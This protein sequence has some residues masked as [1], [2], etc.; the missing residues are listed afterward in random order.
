[1]ITNSSASL[2]T[3]VESVA[4]S[5]RALSGSAVGTFVEFYDFAIYA[6]T[7]PII[8]ESFFPQGNESV[9][10]LSTLAVYGVAFVVRPAGGIVF[11]VL[12][13]RIGRRRVLSVV[14]LLIGLSTAAI[15][16]LPTYQTVGVLA[17]ALLVVLRLLQGLSAG[18]EVTSATSFALE[19]APKGRRSTWITAVIATSAVSSI[20][21]LIVVLGLSSAMSESDFDSWG[22][23][24]PFLLALPLSVVGLYIRLRTEE[25]PAF[26]RARE[27][28]TLSSAPLRESVRTQGCSIAFAA[29]LASMSA[30]AF[31]YLVGY[32]PTYLQV[33]AGMER[34]PAFITNGIA[35]AAFTVLLILCG[36][37]GDDIGRRPMIRTGA[38]LLAVMS[39]P[40]F[41]LAAHGGALALVAQLLVAASLAVFGGGSYAALLEIFPTRTRLTGA[42]LGYNIGYA[43]FGGTAALLAAWLVESSGRP[44]APGIYLACMALVALA[45]TWRLPESRDFDVQ[46]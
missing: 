15:G 32:F 8:A 33:T 9:A 11:G 25:S 19:H 39:A 7:V 22:W 37:L 40:A 28:E 20:V 30:L 6:L 14:L 26:V 42:A 45:A 29:A 27:E 31:Y 43:V 34:T 5:R 13:D 17:P 2:H 35:L 3:S 12:G 4:E 41:Y 44:Q 24:V 23:R 18:G 46:R 1:M 38:V 21:G 16:L 36:R 10:L